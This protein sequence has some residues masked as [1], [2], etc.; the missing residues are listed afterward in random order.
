M[1]HYKASDKNKTCCWLMVWW[2]EL[3]YSQPITPTVAEAEGEPWEPKENQLHQRDAVIAESWQ[4]HRKQCRS[5]V[6]VREVWG[7]FQECGWCGWSMGRGTS[8]CGQRSRPGMVLGIDRRCSVNIEGNEDGSCHSHAP[9]LPIIFRIQ[10]PDLAR[11]LRTYISCL[12]NSPTLSH[13]SPWLV[14][15]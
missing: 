8:I 14:L 7:L 11:S 1:T 4:Q 13:S 12:L 15:L 9:N 2:E 10:S 6:K 3:M 5:W